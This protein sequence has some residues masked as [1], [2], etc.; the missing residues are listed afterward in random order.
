MP[1]DFLP[2][3]AIR[4]R[5]KINLQWRNLRTLPRSRRS[6]SPSPVTQP[7]DDRTLDRMWRENTSPLGS[8][9]RKTHK[10]SLI[11]RK[12][13]N[14]S[15]RTVLLLSTWPMILKIIKVIK[16]KG[17]QRNCHSLEEPKDTGWPN[18]TWNP[19]QD[20]RTEKG[21]KSGLCTL[22]NNNNNASIRDP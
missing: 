6:R 14:K 19:G 4:K 18:V 22:Y 5:R 21:I 16:S 3:T 10:P 15:P 8:S 17:S 11:M 13:A 1:D 2:K 9:P 12:S 7:V 20:P